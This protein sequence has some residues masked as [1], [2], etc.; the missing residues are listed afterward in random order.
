M[1]FRFQCMLIQFFF[2]GEHLF[3]YYLEYAR[4]AQH[5]QS[6]VIVTETV[7]AA[8]PK[9]LLSG[10]LWEKLADLCS[11]PLCGQPWRAPAEDRCALECMENPTPCQVRGQY[12]EI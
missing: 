12:G 11:K 5:R 6:R 2:G 9:Y 1:K 4:Y 10:P 7:W 8:K 3:A